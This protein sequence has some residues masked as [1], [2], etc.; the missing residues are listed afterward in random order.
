[1]LANSH[2][3]VH[4]SLHD[5]GSFACL[6]A[7]AAHRPVICLDLGGPAVIVSDECGFKVSA[8]NPAQAVDEMAKVMRRLA[9]D[10]DLRARMGAAAG[11]RAAEEFNWEKKI[12]VFEHLYAEI[13]QSPKTADLIEKAANQTPSESFGGESSAAAG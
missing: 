6:E 9:N 3:L 8:D 2:V 11:R 12:E 10:C 5:S 7:M 4:P 13:L 1:M